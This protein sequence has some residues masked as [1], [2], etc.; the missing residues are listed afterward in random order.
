MEKSRESVPIPENERKERIYMCGSCGFSTEKI[1]DLH[2]DR[3]GGGVTHHCPECKNYTGQGSKQSW[4]TRDKDI[5]D[6]EREYDVHYL[7]GS[8]GVRDDCRECKG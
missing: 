3:E 8:Y 4:E 5:E 6:A 7:D 2:E 1:E